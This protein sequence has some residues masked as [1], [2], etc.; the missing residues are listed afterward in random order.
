[1]EN[2][3]RDVD[4]EQQWSSNM[5]SWFSWWCYWLAPG[6]LE[7]RQG[8]RTDAARLNDAC[9]GERCSL[10]YRSSGRRRP[11][12][13]VLLGKATTGE[14][15]A[16]EDEELQWPCKA[17]V[18]CRRGNKRRAARRAAGAHGGLD[19]ELYRCACGG[20]CRNNSK[21]MEWKW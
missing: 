14:V 4:D 5:M 13:A 9:G 17:V 8:R 15:P 7:R 19:L 16:S 1:M 11:G 20:S 2:G 3:G 6:G 12:P 18:L 10:A 21:T